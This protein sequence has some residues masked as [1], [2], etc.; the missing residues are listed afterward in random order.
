MCVVIKLYACMVSFVLKIKSNMAEHPPCG[1][2]M[3]NG[4]RCR[5]IRRVFLRIM[6]PSSRHECILTFLVANHCTHCQK[7]FY[8]LCVCTVNCHVMLHEVPWLSS[9]LDGERQFCQ[10]KD[11]VQVELTI[12]RELRLPVLCLV[13]E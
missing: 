8:G 4:E 6:I 9:T 10:V 1:C 5:S 2:C 13:G 11:A 12:G 3:G 7:W